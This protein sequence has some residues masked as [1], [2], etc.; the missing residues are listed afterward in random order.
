MKGTVGMQTRVLR[1]G[2]WLYTERMNNIE[3]DEA[4]VHLRT[5]RDDGRYRNLPVYVV[6]YDV[7]GDT[8]AVYNGN[9]RAMLAERDGR[10]LEVA[11]IETPADWTVAESEQP[12]S[13]ITQTQKLASSVAVCHATAVRAALTA[14]T[15]LARHR[16]VRTRESGKG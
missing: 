4:I 12:T 11:V 7:P 5:A 13:W 6:P 3:D 14:A 15:S 10:D 1:V 16:T 8:Y 9:H 2:Q